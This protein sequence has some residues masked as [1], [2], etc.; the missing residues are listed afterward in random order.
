MND[1]TTIKAL[2]SC[3]GD[4]G[5]VSYETLEQIKWSVPESSEADANYVWL[6]IR[7]FVDDADIRAKDASYDKALRT[8]VAVSYEDLLSSLPENTSAAT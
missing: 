8:C 1:I 7:R 3:I 4:G 6:A 2:V 5:E